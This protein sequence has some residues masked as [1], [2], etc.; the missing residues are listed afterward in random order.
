V[1]CLVAIAAPSYAGDTAY[2]AIIL[3][4]FMRTF[5]KKER[6]KKAKKSWNL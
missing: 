6:K 5:E 3:V 1:L 4:T 2:Y